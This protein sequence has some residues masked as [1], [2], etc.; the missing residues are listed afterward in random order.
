MPLETLVVNSVQSLTVP[1]PGVQEVL[2]AGLQAILTAEVP[3]VQEIL[4][5]GEQGPPGP[6]GPVGPSG[7]PN[8]I[9]VSSAPG[10]SIT[11]GPDGG[12]FVQQLWAAT[13]AW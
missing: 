10:N 2:T 6:I 13:P 9:P 5:A 1:A 4:T 12:L 11:L 7:P 3:G 8:T